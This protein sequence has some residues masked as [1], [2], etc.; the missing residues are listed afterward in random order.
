M[1]AEEAEIVSGA[2]PGN[3]EVLLGFGGRGFFEDRF[4]LVEAGVPRNSFSSDHAIVGKEA[5]MSCL[6]CGD[7]TIFL[8]CHL[9][10]LPHATAL[11]TTEVKVVAYE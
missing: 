2:Q 10:E 1:H 9:N 7:R 6:Y 11:L 5:F 3:D 4:D 8:R